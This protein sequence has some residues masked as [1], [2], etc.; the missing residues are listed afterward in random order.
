M[1]TFDKTVTRFLIVSLCYLY[2]PVPLA[3]AEMVPTDGMTAASQVQSAR[4]K[5]ARDLQREDVRR[6]LERY[7]VRPEQARARIDALSDDEVAAVAGRIETLPAGGEFIGAL[8]FV[9]VLLL[10]TDIFGFTKVF[11]F[12]RSVKK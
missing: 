3:H 9:F 8:V 6:G 4:Q 7:G 10:I 5:L 11:P 1:N 2:Q 12:T